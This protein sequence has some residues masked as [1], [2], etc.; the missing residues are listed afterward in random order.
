MH[1]EFFTEDQIPEDKKRYIHSVAFSD[2][3][4]IERMKVLAIARSEEELC[5]KLLFPSIVK[6]HRDAIRKKESL[7]VCIRQQQ[8]EGDLSCILQI[9]FEG[10]ATSP[11]K[12]E[13]SHSPTKEGFNDGSKSSG[14]KRG[15]KS[16]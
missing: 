1:Q 11:E 6:I 8:F 14:K 3:F 10:A 12:S 15:S 5:R 4:S 9:E 16:P 2:A 13:K 7:A